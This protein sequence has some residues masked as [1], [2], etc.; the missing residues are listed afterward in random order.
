MH[1]LIHLLRAV[2]LAGLA[3]AAPASSSAEELEPAAISATLKRAANWQ[4]ANPSGTE[5]RDWIIAPFYDG[6]LRTAMATGDAK[7]LAAVIRFGTQSGWT[8]SNR[9]YHADDH[10]VGHAWL[11]VYLLDPSRKERL[12]P[13]RDRL[14]RVIAHPITEDLAFGTRPQ[15]KGVSITDRWTWCDA[16]YMAPPTLVRLFSATGDRKYLEFMD[17]EFQATYDQLYDRE[18]KLFFRDASFFDKKTPNGRKT[19]WSRGNGWV[20]GGLALTLEHLP[21]DHPKRGFYET[22]FKEMTT[23]ILAAQ[24]EDGLWR[25]SL[26]DPEEVPVGETSGSGFF[27]FGLAW[28]VNHGLLDRAA[29]VPAIARAWRGLMTRVRADGL[30]GYV[31]PV[32]AAPDRLEAGSTNDYG[33]G[34]LLLA[35]SEILRLLGTPAAN[36]KELLAA[37]EKL[38]AQM[39]IPR[40]YARLVPERMDDLA[41]ENDKVAFRVYGPALRSGP[42][43]SGID[44][45]CKRVA[46]P[47]IDKW[48]AD[49]LGRGISYHKDHGEGLDA[50][51]VGDARGCGGLGLWIDGKLVTSD[52]YVSAEIIWTRP[53]LAEFHTVYRYPV[54]LQ[55]KPLF[56][57]RVT[58]LRLGERL[59][60]ITSTFS[61]QPNQRFRNRKPGIQLPHE[62]AIG[63]NTQDKGAS[64]TLDPAAGIIAVHESLAGSPLGT[65]VIVPPAAVVRTTRLAAADKDGKAEQAL[66]IVRPDDQGRVSYRAGFAWGADGEITTEAA[67]LAYLKSRQ[68]P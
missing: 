3:F 4:L 45:W 48:Y 49:D 25:P 61:T 19:F 30:V 41:W 18:E 43:D 50:Y 53:D 26:L 59:C 35:G 8:P 58:R 56:E 29:H 66:V 31:Q 13:M 68:Q 60:D 54:K 33:T 27:T 57:Y 24:Q 11:D 44:I 67:W 1:R 51:K 39:S 36:G 9:V 55:G 52:T 23:A 28:G 10:A 63:L 14:S 38:V 6:L 47:V 46:R 2:L 7:Y 22:L 17:R 37:A 16:L 62:V 64:M 21:A 5:L 65:G 34:A 42:E 32:G 12:A 40:A 20:Y 15:T